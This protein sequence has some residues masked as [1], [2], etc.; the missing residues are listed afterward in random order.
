MRS[1]RDRSAP[2]L[3][4]VL[5]DENL[6]PGAC[7]DLCVEFEHLRVVVNDEDLRHQ[8]TV[9]PLRARRE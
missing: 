6:M 4:P 7:Q 3:R 1:A 8:I 5:R 9:L 2:N